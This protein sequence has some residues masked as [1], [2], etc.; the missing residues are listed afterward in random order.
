MTATIKFQSG[1]VE[2]KSFPSLI[3]LAYYIEDNDYKV[4]AIII[5]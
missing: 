4:S 3:D 2:V 5:H 1:E